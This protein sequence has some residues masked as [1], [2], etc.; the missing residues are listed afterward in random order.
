MQEMIINS[1]MLLVILAGF[2]AA[3][4]VLSDVTNMRRVA[5]WL[6]GRALYLENLQAERERCRAMGDDL[7]R[8]VERDLGV[9]G[10]EA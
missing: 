1:A 2:T 4:V 8:E 9:A 6:V 10:R 3:V 7:R 5:A